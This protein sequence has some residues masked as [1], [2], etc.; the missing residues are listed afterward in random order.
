[1]KELVKVYTKVIG[2]TLALGLFCGLLCS[3]KLATPINQ[4][5][6]LHGY[7]F[8][9]CFLAVTVRNAYIKDNEELA[10]I[11]F[12]AVLSFELGAWIPCIGVTYWR[13]GQEATLLKVTHTLLTKVGLGFEYGPILA[14]LAY[15]LVDG[16]LLFAY[17]K[18][19]LSQTHYCPNCKTKY[20]SEF[21]FTPRHFNEKS[22]LEVMLKTGGENLELLLE[23]AEEDSDGTFFCAHYCG[24]CEGL[25]RLSVDKV[26]Q[27]SI[28]AGG[29]IFEEVDVPI[30]TLQAIR[31]L[32]HPMECDWRE[33]RANAIAELLAEADDHMD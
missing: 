25:V 3:Y 7:I 30:E 6:L 20:K 12:A 33:T 16:L 32:G 22:Q 28:G 11:A 15:L 5:V 19:C 31:S 10:F 13:M 2:K 8:A 26:V 29:Y 14:V 27:G 18:V 23:D 9:G 4:L 21:Y 17:Y 1:M 24:S